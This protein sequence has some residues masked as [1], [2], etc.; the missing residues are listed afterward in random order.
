LAQS[1]NLRGEKTNKVFK[2]RYWFPRYPQRTRVRTDGLQR[3]EIRSR[4]VDR[5]KLRLSV[6]GMIRGFG[7]VER[8]NKSFGEKS[9]I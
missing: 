1:K 5:K 8:R 4:N 6:T 2:Q 9:G 3:D 7:D